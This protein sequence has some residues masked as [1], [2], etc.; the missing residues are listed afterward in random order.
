MS[1]L[2]ERLKAGTSNTTT[3][4]FLGEDVTIRILSEAELQ[5][6]RAVGMKVIEAAELDDEALMVEIALQQLYLAVSDADGNR[7]AKTYA[8]FKALLSR[9]EREYLVGEYLELER[10]CS[11][12]LTTMTDEEFQALE[13][14]VKKTPD[15]LLNASGI[16][17]L[18]KL[19]RYL[20]GRQSS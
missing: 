5:Q 15:L 3:V 12:S 4:Q 2:L 6:C 8:A 16:D 17:L 1:L 7:L 11:P 20:A 9:S 18:K 19:C 14:E 13:M 10:A